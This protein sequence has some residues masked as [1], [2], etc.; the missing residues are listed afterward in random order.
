ML[1]AQTGDFIAAVTR[2]GLER[3]A[4]ERRR[5]KRWFDFGHVH[6]YFQSRLAVTTQR[7]FN[8]L[9]V[10]GGVLTKSSRDAAKM[11]AEAAWF[12]DAPA[13]IRPFLPNLIAADI[14]AGGRT[15]ADANAD[16]DAGYALEYL[17]L[18]ALNELYVFGRLPVKV[19]RKIFAGC[20][21]FFVAARGIE[22]AKA[23]DDGFSRHTYRDKTLARL[24][25]FA[26]QTGCDLD[27]PWRFNGRALPGLRTMAEQAAAAMCAAPPVAS[28]VHG[29]FCFSNILYDF[30]SHRIKLI[31]PRGIDVAGRITAFGDFRY[32]IAKLAHSV[33]G[34]Y[35]VVLA[36]FYGLRIDRQEVEFT[37]S[38]RRSRPIRDAFLQTRFAGATPAEWGCW[39]AMVLLFLSMLPLHVDRR[40]RQQA[41]MA[42][43]L[44]VYEA[45]AAAMVAAAP[46]VS[47][48]AVAAPP[49]LGEPAP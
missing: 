8:R 36:G 31:D 33:V 13:R 16:A 43:C 5:L 49:L 6:T 32:D 37:V 44:R 38:H 1:L 28:F 22:A 12:A 48:A 42:N 35:D 21:A 4:L 46:D 30:R 23:L 27:A 11:R 41:L 2:Y 45:W 9:S 29:D 34:L 14:A 26:R 15:G 17:P 24:E 10:A 47:D 18:T 3:T 20:D 25:D 39:P 7:H 19:W 40:E